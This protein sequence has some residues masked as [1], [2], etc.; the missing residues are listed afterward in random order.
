MQYIFNS[1]SLEEDKNGGKYVSTLASLAGDPNDRGFKLPF[2]NPQIINAVIAAKAKGENPSFQLDA[3]I[4]EETVQLGAVYFR[5]A[6]DAN[7][8]LLDTPAIDTATNKPAVYRKIRVHTIFQYSMHDAFYVEGERK[9]MRIMEDVYENG[10]KV[11]R[12]AKAFDLDDF[13]R[14]IR[15]YMN[16][17]AP[18]ERKNQILKTFFMLAPQEYQ[19]A[20]VATEA[21]TQ[22]QAPAP[23]PS[24]Q[25]AAEGLFGGGQA[26]QGQQAQAANAVDPLAQ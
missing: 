16:G 3:E 13:G 11:S 6:S 20:A 7:G 1:I 21:P 4:E 25:N 22:Q 14:P 9:G 8:R 10:Q 5:R 24:L 12:P 2:F 26:Q 18:E 23:E 15:K 19:D 17:W